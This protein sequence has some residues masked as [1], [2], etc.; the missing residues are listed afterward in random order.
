[1]VKASR[2]TSTLPTNK[3]NKPTSVL[4][5]SLHRI[6]QSSHGNANNLFRQSGPV[7]G[8]GILNLIVHL[9]HLHVI[10]GY[11]LFIS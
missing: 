6:S 4:V 2:D 7:P 5:I 9:Q 3:Y 10:T 8:H 11:R 1:M